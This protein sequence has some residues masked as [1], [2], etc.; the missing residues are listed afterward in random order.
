MKEGIYQELEV[1]Y[2]KIVKRDK[3]LMMNDPSKVHN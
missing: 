2:I 1:K 3:E